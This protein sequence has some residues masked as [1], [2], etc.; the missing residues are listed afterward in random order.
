[1]HF[2]I[3]GT[4]KPENYETFSLTQ[5][6]LVP[7]NS[8]QVLT[9]FPNSYMV[10]VDQPGV[11]SLTTQSSVPQSLDIQ[12][13]TIVDSSTGT[14]ASYD[15]DTANNVFNIGFALSTGTANSADPT[16][17]TYL[18][19]GQNLMLIYA[20]AVRDTDGPNGGVNTAVSRMKGNFK[21]ASSATIC[22]TD[23]TRYANLSI[24]ATDT[25]D[26]GSP[27]TVSVRQRGA[28]GC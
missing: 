1:M 13:V 7:T 9:T 26:A 19:G 2:Y 23:G 20:P 4:T 17:R 10:A 28:S 24:G 15:Y 14:P 5:P 3:S 12:R 6:R 25:N 11:V 8:T 18:T 16:G 22:L 21:I 27:F